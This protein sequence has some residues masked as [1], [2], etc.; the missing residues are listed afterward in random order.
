MGTAAHQDIFDLDILFKQ[1]RLPKTQTAARSAKTAGGHPHLVGGVPK[2]TAAKRG[3]RNLGNG[4]SAWL[5]Q[6]SRFSLSI[7]FPHC[8]QRRGW[9]RASNP[10]NPEK[11]LTPGAPK[12]LLDALR[13]A[14]P[15]ILLRRKIM[16]HWQP[17][18]FV[19]HEQCIKDTEES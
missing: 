7:R 9:T 4:V 11:T 15:K 17:P 19:A 13:G 1:G 3:Y 5:L 14:K 12:P 8:L 6:L 16:S 18:E 10:V 2:G